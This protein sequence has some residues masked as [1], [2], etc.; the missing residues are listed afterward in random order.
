MGLDLRVD[1][2]GGAFIGMLPEVSHF[3]RTADSQV[4]ESY[5]EDFRIV[6]SVKKT[7]DVIAVAHLAIPHITAFRINYI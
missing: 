7:Y 6:L 3:H 2:R 5:I 4:R 1:C